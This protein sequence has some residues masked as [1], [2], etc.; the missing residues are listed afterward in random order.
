MSAYRFLYDTVF[1]TVEAVT[2]VNTT[3]DFNGQYE[4]AEEYKLVQYPAVYVEGSK[5]VWDKNLNNFD[6]M[7]KEPQTGTAEIKLHIVYH[8]LESFTRRTKDDFFTL[9]DSVTNSVQRLQCPPTSVGSFSTLL[10]IE[11]EY[12]TPEKQLRVAIITFETQLTDIFEEREQ[13][14]EIITATLNLDI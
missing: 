13:V 11:E 3:L 9:I 12:L 7:G 14:Q 6:D 2:E 4:E 10:R 8:T 5:V 1:D